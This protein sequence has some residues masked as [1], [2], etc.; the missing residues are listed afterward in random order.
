MV[1]GAAL[2][3]VLD[4]LFI[5]VM[6]MG[7][8]GA[9]LA[10]VISQGFSCLWMLRFLTSSQANI[11]LTR[12]NLRFD[13]QI[14]MRTVSLGVSP[15]TMTFTES[16]IQVVLNRG[17]MLYGGDMYVGTMTIITSVVN[18]FS[19]PLHGYTHGV[20]PLL[21]F[22]YGAGKI[23]RVRKSFKLLLFST[24]AIT[25]SYCVLIELFPPA[26]Y[27]PVCTRRSAH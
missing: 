20:Q 10:T 16:A 17:M 4:P 5:F 6:D 12:D 22:N 18:L 14:L 8:R 1:I 15:F 13:R 27:P 7:V 26:V 25:M 21:S 2:N 23:D 24:V 19:N 9:A 3:I 11:R